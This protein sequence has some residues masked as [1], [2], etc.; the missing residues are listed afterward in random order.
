[1]QPVLRYTLAALA[2]ASLSLPSVAE[3]KPA[4][5]RV[6]AIDP[7]RSEVAFDVIHKLHKVHGAS[8]AAEGKA[9]LHPDGRLQVMVRVPVRSFDSGDANRDSHMREVLEVGKHAHVTFKGVARLPRPPE[10]GETVTVQLAGELEFHGHKARE[11]VPVQLS[12][13]SA[14][15]ARATGSFQVSLEKYKVERPSL[16][17]VKVND[18]CAIGFD[19]QL[20]DEA[21]RSAGR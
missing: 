11:T 16:L 6:L 3:E 13:T 20:V 21:A 5:A 2:V 1:M 4:A 7:A 8:K 10:P 9:A 17:F 18:E 14:T 15:E 19:L 12:F